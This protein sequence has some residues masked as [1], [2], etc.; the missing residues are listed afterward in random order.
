[1][2]N[3]VDIDNSS[4]TEVGSSLAAERMTRSRA[5]RNREERAAR[6]VANTL[7]RRNARGRQSQG[8][9]AATRDADTLAR[10]TARASQSQGERTATREVNTLAR[11]T[12]RARQSQGERAAIR[13]ANTL[14][15]IMLCPYPLQ[16]HRHQGE[17]N[18]HQ[19][20]VAKRAERA[21]Y[22]L[23]LL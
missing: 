7:A 11:R 4:V 10:E 19:T 17:R 15:N 3:F 13:D 1:M 6:S 20:Q 22:L 23:L 14:Q 5:R 9:R 2:A 12:A 16:L 18:D 8:E 21:G